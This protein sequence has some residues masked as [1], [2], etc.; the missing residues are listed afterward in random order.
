MNTAPT[1]SHSISLL[2]QPIPL[3]LPNKY[4]DDPDFVGA[5]K[6]ALTKDYEDLRAGMSV[7]ISHDGDKE[8]RQKISLVLQEEVHC[9]TTEPNGLSKVWYVPGSII[10]TLL[11]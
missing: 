3:V 4:W 6:F 2:D 1:T 7:Y 11:T 9:V 10:K 8:T 5:A